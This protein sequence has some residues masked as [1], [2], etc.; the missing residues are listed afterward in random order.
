MKTT[1]Q[2]IDE[3]MGMV[4]YAVEQYKALKAENRALEKQCCVYRKLN[5]KLSKENKRLN[6]IVEGGVQK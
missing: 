2:L 6:M 4:N 3:V 1:D 5:A